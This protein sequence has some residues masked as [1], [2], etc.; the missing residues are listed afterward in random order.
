MRISG[1][2]NI[3]GFEEGLIA[4]SRLGLIIRGL[5]GGL[6]IRMSEHVVPMRYWL[7]ISQ[8]VFL[9][10]TPKTVTPKEN[11][12]KLFCLGGLPEGESIFSSMSC[13]KFECWY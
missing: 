13:G 12:F 7:N 6:D 2:K 9:L 10:R 5:E 11:D 3:P 8:A 1:D 4:T